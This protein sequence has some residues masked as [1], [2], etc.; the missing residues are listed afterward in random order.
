MSKTRPRLV[1]V[2]FRM[3]SEA[4]CS[5]DASLA[6][7]TFRYGWASRITQRQLDEHMVDDF[8]VVLCR[9]LVNGGDT[10]VLCKVLVCHLI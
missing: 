3:V 10:L 2:S 8:E 6:A 1:P 7:S 4:Y 9:L 5:D